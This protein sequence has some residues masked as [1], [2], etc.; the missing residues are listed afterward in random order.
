MPAVSSVGSDCSVSLCSDSSDPVLCQ[1]R[2][3]GPAEY[4]GVGHSGLVGIAD[5]ASRITV[6]YN[7]YGLSEI[8]RE[9]YF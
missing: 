8:L 5:V 1:P 6:F 7:K 4:V 2:L 9:K 3:T